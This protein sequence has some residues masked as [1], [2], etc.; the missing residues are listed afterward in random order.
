MSLRGLL[1]AVLR[2]AA[3]YSPP[4]LFR[5]T[6]SLLLVRP[7]ASLTPHHAHLP[8]LP[9]IDDHA[10]VHAGAAT[11]TTTSG[12]S[13][14]YYWQEVVRGTIDRRDGRNRYEDPE[15]A[16]QRSARAQSAEGKYFGLSLAWLLSLV[17]FGFRLVQPVYGISV[18]V[19]I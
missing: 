9:T 17:W 13:R 11:A 12:S 14:R 6:T 18:W 8:Y 7:S 4:S 3:S 15:A 2:P 1:S 10:G 5:C 16:A 19:P